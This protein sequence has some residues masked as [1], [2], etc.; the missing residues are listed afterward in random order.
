MPA[1]GSLALTNARLPTLPRA[2]SR[3]DAIVAR[4]GKI[5]WIGDTRH[6]PPSALS[7]IKPIDCDGATILPG[8]I[9]AHCHILAYAASL[10]AV[11]C[12]P[13]AVSSI[14]DIA[15]VIRRRAAQTPPGEWIRATGYSDFHLAEK[16]HPTRRDLDAAAPDNPVRLNHRS[17]HACVLNSLALARVGIRPDTPEPPG[18]T[19]A[20]ELDTAL[21][22]GLLLDMDA[23]LDDRIPRLA[24]ADLRHGIALANR[25]FLAAGVATAHDATPANSPARW[26]ALTRLV[27]SRE[28]APSLMIMPGATRLPEFARAGL[29]YG[30]EPAREHPHDHA[31]ATTTLGHAKFMLTLSGGNP[32]PS[33][34][35][36]S[37]AIAAAHRHGFPVAIHAVEAS[38]VHAA[39]TALAANPA[40]RLRDRI[41]HA[42]ECPPPTLDALRKAN[43]VVVSQPNF[44]HDSGNRYIAQLGEQS[45]WLYRFGSIA[46]SGLTLAASSDAPVTHPDPL[47]AIRAAVTRRASS[48]EILE[49]AE[50]VSVVRAL[51]MHT[52][53]AA[54]AACQEND[55]GA[56][57]PGMRADL[58][59]L[60]HDPTTL[61][62]DRLSDLSVTMTVIGG[63]IAW[64]A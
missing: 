21:L 2:R 6:I 19:I 24:P 13:S 62:P 49:P 5:A 15:R 56:I 11:D 14:P 41:E 18:T 39:A 57:A 46:K 61:P 33:Y 34:D 55:R 40:P 48:G 53:A 10:L 7:G 42:S 36:L 16:R 23:F 44:I 4:N 35:D 9:D 51:A 54:Y 59:A 47:S 25:R 64:Q 37:H 52:T 12:S 20:R 26:R 50:R 32:H 43:P 60:N 1:P 63:N 45:R 58:V 38:A 27:Q 8:F 31:P 28:F 22:S 17:G 30:S 29:V 3:P